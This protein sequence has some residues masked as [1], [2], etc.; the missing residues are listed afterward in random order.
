MA[1][2]IATITGGGLDV[3]EEP[4]LLSPDPVQSRLERLYTC[5]IGNFLVQSVP[6]IYDSVGKEMCSQFSVLVRTVFESLENHFAEVA[7]E[8]DDESVLRFA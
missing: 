7:K 6:S 5:C 1:Y 3:H 2:M 8:D 4:D